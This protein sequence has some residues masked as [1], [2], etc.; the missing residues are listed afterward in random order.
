MLTEPEP[1]RPHE[2]QIEPPDR[3][4]AAAETAVLGSALY[5][6]PKGSRSLL[7]AHIQLS[8][9]KNPRAAATY[10]AVQ[11]LTDRGGHVDEIP[12]RWKLTHSQGVWGPGLELAELTRDRF[13]GQLD[14]RDIRTVTTTAQ[15]RALVKASAT[16]TSEARNLA[17]DLSTT[18]TRV[19]ESLTT[20]ASVSRRLV[21]APY[22]AGEQR[23]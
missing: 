4:L 13:T 8:D 22:R 10:H 7:I 16:V 12:V 19:P 5:D 23:I 2:L 3:D 20:V 15:R 9:F 21:P 11:Q 6:W 1:V 17:T 18:T 14:P